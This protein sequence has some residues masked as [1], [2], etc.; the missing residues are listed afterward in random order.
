ML[1]LK[2]DFYAAPPVFRP[3][4]AAGTPLVAAFALLTLL[5]CILLEGLDP[6]YL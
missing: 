5:S 1:L 2:F 3:P 4:P 6:G